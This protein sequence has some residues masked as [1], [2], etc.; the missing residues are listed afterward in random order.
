MIRKAQEFS[1]IKYIDLKTCGALLSGS[2]SCSP[3]LWSGKW[4]QDLCFSP[5]HVA[6]SSLKRG[7]LRRCGCNTTIIASYP[8]ILGTWLAHSPWHGGRSNC[9]AELH[10]GGWSTS[11]ASR[12][13][14][15]VEEKLA[16]EI[17]D[18]LRGH[19]CRVLV[20]KRSEIMLKVLC[21]WCDS[22][23]PWCWSFIAPRN[24][25]MVN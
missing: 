14:R 13:P 20:S 25:T 10:I 6:L 1:V 16:R 17:T 7:V 9:I 19:L 23:W 11:A 2:P 3:T 15:V 8:L 12:P 5:T 18:L 24:R 4:D 21:W 22:R